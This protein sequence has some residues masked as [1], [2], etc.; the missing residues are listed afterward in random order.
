MESWLMQA[1]HPWVFVPCGPP[2]LVLMFL[3]ARYRSLS[4]ARSLGKCPRFLVT[5]RS[6]EL[7]GAQKPPGPIDHRRDTGNFVS[8]DPASDLDWDTCNDL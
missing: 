2:R 1:F 5:L 7:P 3:M 8:V 4:A 6:W